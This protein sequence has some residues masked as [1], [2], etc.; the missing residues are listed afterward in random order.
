MNTEVS[1]QQIAATIRSLISKTYSFEAFL[2]DRAAGA[3]ERIRQQIKNKKRYD[4][5][6]K[7][8]ESLKIEQV[9]K[10]DVINNS[11]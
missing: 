8:K 9:E 4:A 6:K 3:K 5:K 11:D 1:D 2:A 7:L 10:L